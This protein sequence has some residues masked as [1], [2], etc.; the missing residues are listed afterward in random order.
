MKSPKNI[1]FSKLSKKGEFL[2]LKELKPYNGYYYEWNGRFFGGK[3][4]NSANIELIKNTSINKKGNINLNK[5]TIYNRFFE[6]KVNNSNS[7]KEISENEYKIKLKNPLYKTIKI[8]YD[9]INKDH[10]IESGD[11]NNID[12]ILPFG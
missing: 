5:N 1:I 9:S 7:I 4:Y 11:I 2:E 12:L 3:E 8:K 6:Y 10:I